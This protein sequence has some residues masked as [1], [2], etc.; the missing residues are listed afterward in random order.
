[1]TLLPLYIV[2]DTEWAIGV[3]FAIRPHHTLL[4]NHH[5]LFGG[6]ALPHW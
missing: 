1:M 6:I 3:V 2:Y 4:S 5:G